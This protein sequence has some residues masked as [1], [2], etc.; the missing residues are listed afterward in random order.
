MRAL[1]DVNVWIA[2]LDPE[3]VFFGRATDWMTQQT[4]EIATCPIVENGVIRVL[5][6]P[7]YGREGATPSSIAT[8]LAQACA[9]LDHVFWPDDVSLLDRTKFDFDRL[10][11]HRQLTDAYLLGLATARGGFL[12]TLDSAIPLSAVRGATKKHLRLL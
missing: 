8:L 5:S 7:R 12:V 3:H 4:R 2:L 9:K 1:L 6:A 11:G 10:H